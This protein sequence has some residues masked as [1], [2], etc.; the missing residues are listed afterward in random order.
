MLRSL[1]IISLLCASLGWLAGVGSAD[2]RARPD[3]TA[4]ATP[5]GQRVDTGPFSVALPPGWTYVPRKGIDSFVGELLGPDMRL[6]FDYG[7]YWLG[8]PEPGAD[9]YEVLQE[10][11]DWRP[12]DIWLARKAPATVT[13][14]YVAAVNDPAAGR[15]A[16]KLSLVGRNLTPTQQDQALAIIRSLHFRRVIPDSGRWEVAAELPHTSLFELT[17]RDDGLPLVAGIDYG[18]SGSTPVGV[19]YNP[20]D[21]EWQRQIIT[22]TRVMGD[23]DGDWAVEYGGQQV[24]RRDAGGT[25]RTALADVPARLFDIQV[26]NRS[27]WVA[28]TRAILHFDGATWTNLPGLSGGYSIDLIDDD[29]GWVAGGQSLNQQVAGHWQGIAWPGKSDE[30]ILA[31]DTLSEREAWFAGG[32]DNRAGSL[33]HWQDGT[34]HQLL[35]PTTNLWGI[36]VVSSAEG[37]AVGGNLSGQVP[38][39][40][41]RLRD[42]TWSATSAGDSCVGHLHAVTVAPDG[43]TWAV[44]YSKV[45]DSDAEQRSGL[46]LRYA[47]PPVPATETPSVSPSPSTTSF[48]TS[49]PTATPGRRL[50]LPFGET[51]S[52]R[53]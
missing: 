9:G 15:P 47:A 18:I 27:V 19:L 13:G 11:V 43:T 37:W 45:V 49:T 51:V 10:T 29:N 52:V 35:S 38:C 41:L 7:E 12:A 3:Q 39:D 53:G 23:V 46:V 32:N 20:R 5:A 25:W 33:W 21:G 50:Y 44:G 34:W 24:L 31:V 1:T 14:L 30:S 17:L 26:V 36:D 2:S 6:T 28:G 22:G 8:R 48:P 40:L 16:T 4:T 42:G